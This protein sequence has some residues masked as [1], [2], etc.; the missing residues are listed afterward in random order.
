MS[1]L[2]RMAYLEAMGIECYISRVQLPGAAVSRRKAI[3]RKPRA[4][5]PIVAPEIPTIAVRT[6]R[7][8]QVSP[9]E[10]ENAVA[11]PRFSLVTM[12]AGDWLWLEQLGDMP[13][14]TEQVQLVQAMAHALQHCRPNVHQAPP[15]VARPDVLLFEWPMHNNRQLD[16][17]EE[18]AR[19]GIAAFV[20]RRLEQHQC[21]GVVLLGHACATRVPQQSMQ[22]PTVL[23]A[24]TAEI[25]QTPSLK[26]QVWHD[27]QVLVRT[28]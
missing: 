1:E 19:I 4:T 7:T 28:A 26:R 15:Q 20:S 17:S 23:T 25:L 14:T 5:P 11:V 10:L 12:V 21:R 18:A 16:L 24:S 22:I 2:R 3:V 8:G 13:L 27:L 9:P 6:D